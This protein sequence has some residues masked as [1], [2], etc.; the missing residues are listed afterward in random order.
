M[1]A[2]LRALVHLLVYLSRPFLS[3]QTCSFQL[4]FEEIPIF[5]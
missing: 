5:E 4:H 1:P 2:Q 3:V